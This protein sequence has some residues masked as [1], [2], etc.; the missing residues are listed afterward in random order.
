MKL[1]MDHGASVD[2]LDSHNR[3]AV[4]WALYNKRVLNTMFLLNRGPH[5]LLR[6]S[7]SARNILRMSVSTDATEDIRRALKVALLCQTDAPEIIKCLLQ[8]IQLG[9]RYTYGRTV[10][11]LAIQA[12]DSTLEIIEAVLEHADHINF[13]A[14]NEDGLTALD[15]AARQ[16][17][18]EV[19]RLIDP[20]WTSTQEVAEPVEEFFPNTEQRLHPADMFHWPGLGW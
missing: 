3:S 14:K 19:A 5:L 2:D 9:F 13:N 16:G 15:C 1:L 17:R 11:H 4:L 8:L 18:P 20:E 10:L 6:G 7:R 12:L